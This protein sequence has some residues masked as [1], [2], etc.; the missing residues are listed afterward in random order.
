MP[1]YLRV[2][3]GVVVQ[4]FTT[5]VGFTIDECW[6]P[7]IVGQFIPQPDGVSPQ[8]GWTYDGTTFAEPVAPPV[9]IEVQ[10]QNEL[11]TR[12]VQGITITSTGTPSLNC[13]MAL[14]ANTMNQV[15]SVARDAGA[16]L[17]LPGDD[18]TFTY[19]DIDG[20]PRTFNEVQVIALYKGQRD[21]LLVLNTQMAIMAHGGPPSW[22]DTQAKTIP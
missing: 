1:N 11:N 6:T 19:P 13:V 14:D 9:P 16:G 7:D 20:V 21:L 4:E 17:G 18:D 10:A 12:V 8:Q 3:D 15:G 5:P 2:M 22:P